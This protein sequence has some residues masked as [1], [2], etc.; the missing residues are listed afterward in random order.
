MKKREFIREID[1]R[2]KNFNN[3]E[4]DRIIEYYEELI[5]DYCDEG[6]TEEEAIEKL[7][8]ID[9]IIKNIK[10][11]LVIERSKTKN[12]NSFKNVIIILGICT[13]PVLIPLGIG[14]FFTFF[15]IAFAL[16]MTFISL[17][18][19]SLTAL[20]GTVVSVADLI[21]TGGDPGLIILLLGIGLTATG[22]LGLLAYYLYKLSVIILNSI[23]K[24]F[25]GL[26]KK[27]TNKEMSRSV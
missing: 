8:S 12:T 19:G 24:L 16:F 22:L 7:G 6:Y 18:I 25:S 17:S 4:R 23:I 3:E 27:R 1:R 26:I 13:S 14:L 9:T 21:I 2:L 20:A 15:G 10:A 11:E 5:S